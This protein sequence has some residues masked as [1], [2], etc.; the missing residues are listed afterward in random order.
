MVDHIQQK[1]TLFTL[2]TILINNTQ[3]HVQKTIRIKKENSTYVLNTTYVTGFL[4]SAW[5]FSGHLTLQNETRQHQTLTLLRQKVYLP[6]SLYTR[7]VIN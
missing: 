7:T 2:I 5:Q 6:T 4:L 1:K 3:K